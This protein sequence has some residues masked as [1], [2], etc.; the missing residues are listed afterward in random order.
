E[1]GGHLVGIALATLPGQ[2]EL[3]EAFDQSKPGPTMETDAERIEREFQSACRRS[4]LTTELPP[5]AHITTVATEPALHGSG[6]GRALMD[7]LAEALRSRD[8]EWV[9]L[10]CL[11]SR[12][13]FY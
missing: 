4:H 2:C 12:A 7:A 13:L 11:T 5:H 10:E 6:I 1:A 3:C 9:V 8:V